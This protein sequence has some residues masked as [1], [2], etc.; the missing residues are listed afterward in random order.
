MRR[1]YSAAI[2]AIALVFSAL[3]L[4]AAQD[5]RRLSYEEVPGGGPVTILGAVFTLESLQQTET[6]T[7]S[8]GTI[9]GPLPNAVLVRATIGYDA[10]AAEV[11]PELHC[12]ADLVGAGDAWW[13]AENMEPVD[14]SH[15][16]YCEA[17]RD[18]AIELVFEVPATMIGSVRGVKLSVYDGAALGELVPDR[19]LLSPVS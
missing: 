17:G 19:L 16:Q 14:Q 3:W 15:S 7:D 2:V 6:A 1:R 5:D 4:Y 10:T 12:T 13:S 11:P 8:W 9:W 18:S